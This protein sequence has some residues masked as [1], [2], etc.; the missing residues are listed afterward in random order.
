[1]FRYLLILEKVKLERPEQL[2]AN[3]QTDRGMGT[4]KAIPLSYCVKE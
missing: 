3:G 1:M 2:K 4:K